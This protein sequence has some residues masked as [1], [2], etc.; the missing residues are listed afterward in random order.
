MKRIGPS[1]TF[2][3]E[4]CIAIDKMAAQEPAITEFVIAFNQLHSV[5]FS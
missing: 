2:W 5:A 1:P 4:S 3:K